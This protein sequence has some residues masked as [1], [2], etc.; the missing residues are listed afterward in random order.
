MNKPKRVCVWFL[1]VGLTVIS[2]CTGPT[3]ED[4]PASQVDTATGFPTSDVLAGEDAAC[5]PSTC[6][7]LGAHCG[8]P[9]DGCGGTLSCGDC[10]APLACGVDFRCEC[11]P[12]CVGEVCGEKDGCGGTC[13]LGS[14]CCVADCSEDGAV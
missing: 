4:E 12:L 14:G 10:Q 6:G 3:V 7:D 11:N 5:V 8:A 2:G 1:C 13:E 9:D